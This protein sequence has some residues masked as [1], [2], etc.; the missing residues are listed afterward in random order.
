MNTEYS[1]I[2]SG[3]VLLQIELNDCHNIQGG[4]FLRL[5]QVSKYVYIN[6]ARITLINK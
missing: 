5:W 6:T 3:N 1:K 2:R 4:V